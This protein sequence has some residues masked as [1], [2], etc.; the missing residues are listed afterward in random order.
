MWSR[1]LL[2]E[3]VAHYGLRRLFGRQFDTFL[4]NVYQSAD[5][6]IRSKITEMAAKNSW[7]FRTATEEYLAGLAE[8][9]N[10]DEAQSYSGWWIEIKRLFFDMLEK[11]GF[12][13]FSETG[14]RDYG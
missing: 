13:G 4:D 8:D 10:Y 11:I 2:H 14:I 7:D 1:T 5:E 3:A 6:S 12:R 9:I